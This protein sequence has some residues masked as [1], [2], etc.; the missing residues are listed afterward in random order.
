MRLMAVDF[1][2]SQIGIA[3]GESAPAAFSTRLP[4]PAV[5]ALKKDAQAIAALAGKEEAELVLIGLPVE[6]SGEEGRMAKICRQLA[7]HLTALGLNVELVDETLSS[8][9]A[10][11]AMRDQG[12]RAARRKNLVHG[13]AAVII[14]ERYLHA[15]SSS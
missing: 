10:E 4:I 2:F 8:V 11:G 15:H 7:G 1:G 6:P 3:V 12:V 5:G 9:Q 14:L 13:E